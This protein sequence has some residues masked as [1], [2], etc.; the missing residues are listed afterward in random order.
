MSKRSNKLIRNGGK[1]QCLF[2]SLNE[3]E[4]I[5]FR[6]N[7]VGKEGSLVYTIDHGENREQENGIS[8]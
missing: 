1:R 3:V 6:K 4:A 2:I 5:P 7:H 8:F